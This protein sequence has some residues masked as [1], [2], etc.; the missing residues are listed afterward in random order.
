MAHG[1]NREEDLKHHQNRT[2]L[3]LVARAQL[4]NPHHDAYYQAQCQAG[5]MTAEEWNEAKQ[6]F[7]RP[8]NVTFRIPSSS[9]ATRVDSARAAFVERIERQGN[10]ASSPYFSPKACRVATRP[11]REWSSPKA[12]SDAQDVG[13]V[14][15]QQ[16]SSMVPPLLLFAPTPPPVRVLDLCAAPGSKS[17]QLLDLLPA[18]GILIA[19]DAQ[20]SRAITIP[21][22]ARLNANQK[23]CLIVNSSDGRHFPSLRKWG[24]YKF[25]FDA[26]LADV[27]CSGDGTFRK[28]SS[29]EWEKWSIPHHLSLHKLQLQLLTR[30]LQ[31]VQKGGR[32]VYS[33]CSLDPIENE[34]VVASAI[35]N[36]GGPSVYRIVPPPPFL[37]EDA[38]APFVYSPGATCW[39]VPDP[40]FT[41]GSPRVYQTLEQVPEAIRRRLPISMF[42][43]RSRQEADDLLESASQY[44]GNLE[45]DVAKMEAMLPNCCRILPPHL[46]SGGF[47]C[48]IIER[49]APNFFAICYPKQRD[50]QLVSKTHHGR[51]YHCSEVASIQKLVEADKKSDEEVYY[52]GW[53]TVEAAQQWL[54]Q[55]SA[56]VLDRSEKAIAK[57]DREVQQTN[58]RKAGDDM[59]HKSYQ[60]TPIYTPLFSPP[61]PSLVQEFVDYFGLFTTSEEAADAGVERFPV[62]Q[63]V[64]IGGGENVANVTS[65]WNVDAATNPTAVI[66]KQKVFRLT[67]V[68]ESVRSLYAGGAKFNPI[69]VGMSLCSVS[70][71]TGQYGLIDEAVE[72]MGRCAT[73]RIVALSKTECMQ[74]LENERICIADLQNDGWSKFCGEESVAHRGRL[75]Q[76]IPPGPII[77]VGRVDFSDKASR[78]MFFSCNILEDSLHLL[79]EKRV[80]NAWLQLLRSP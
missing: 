9:S 3:Q 4:V 80:A 74:L 68:S 29:S 40:K 78:K 25:K 41:A 59:H 26:V 49:V 8:L 37:Q 71:M 79:T 66:K 34:A 31:L 20:R 73:K 65:C 56:F 11:P 63:L 47:F 61:H 27:P 58:T 1:Y 18:H 45:M 7:L 39:V 17:L 15:R 77:A 64:T 69:E 43:P 10:V 57:P 60:R 51:I 32:V 13:A 22:R 48:A 67:L 24:G 72:F 5:V 21:R 38:T 54:I 75:P 12:V 42:P 62:E 50:A 6:Y 16:L 2:E 23:N 46:D 36:M 35:W 33:T 19:N 52:E 28:L 70:V 30:S 14:H 55:H 76:E 44:N 53:P